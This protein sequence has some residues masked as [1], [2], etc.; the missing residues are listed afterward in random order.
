MSMAWLAVGCSLVPMQRPVKYR[1]Q[2][3][4]TSV[5]QATRSTQPWEN[6]RWRMQIR[7]S[8]ITPHLRPQSEKAK[9]P[10]ARIP[11]LVSVAKLVDFEGGQTIY[12]DFIGITALPCG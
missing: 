9:L 5:L 2:S 12:S 1:Q 7:R 8:V 11:N 4:G 3:A 10:H 6:L